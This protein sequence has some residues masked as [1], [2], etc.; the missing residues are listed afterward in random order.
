AMDDDFNMPQALA[1]IF[2]LISLGYK[3][4]DKEEFVSS[5]RKLLEE[6]LDVFLI[7]PAP[8][9]PLT[10]T[11]E[12]IDSLILKRDLARRNKD[13]ALADKIREELQELGII[14]EDTKQGTRWRRK[15]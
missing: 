14:L 3:N 7:N 15:I 6:F 10:I 13:F 5:V 9:E 8:K 2:D 1:C 12:E 4:L 11:Q